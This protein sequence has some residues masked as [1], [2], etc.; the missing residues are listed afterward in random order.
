M[1][2][3]MF[4]KY[5]TLLLFC[6]FVASCGSSPEDEAQVSRPE[7]EHRLAGRVQS[8]NEESRFVLIRRYGPWHVREDEVVECRGGDRTANLLPTGEK[9]GE[10]IAADIRQ[11]RVAVGDAVY[12]RRARVSQEAKGLESSQVDEKPTLPDN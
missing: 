8:V 5:L 3:G 9:L 12:I 1:A 10:H 2:I 4:K 11:G 7:S 6:G